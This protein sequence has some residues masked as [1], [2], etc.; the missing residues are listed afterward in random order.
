[1]PISS[2]LTESICAFFRCGVGLQI[3][4]ALLLS[5]AHSHACMSKGGRVQAC[6]HQLPHPSAHEANT[7]SSLCLLLVPG[8]TH[9]SAVLTI[10]IMPMVSRAAMLLYVCMRV[11]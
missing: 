6:M 7:A 9:I 4:L 3:L 8:A 10:C 1:M 5:H 11:S 2:H